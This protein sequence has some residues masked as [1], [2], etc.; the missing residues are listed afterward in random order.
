MGGIA[1]TALC[2]ASL[3]QTPAAPPP[4]GSYLYQPSYAE[5]YVL[6]LPA[7]PY[8]LQEGD[9][10]FAADRKLFWLATH[11][12]AGTWN[13]THSAV[14]FKRPDGTM[15]I[16]EAGPH[17]TRYCSVLDALPHLLSYEMEGRVWIRRRAVPLTKEQ[18][19]LLTEFALAQDGK[20]FAIKRLGQ[21][22]P[23]FMIIFPRARGPL[24]TR[25][26][27]DKPHGIDRESFYCSELCMEAL[28]YAGLVDYET[29]RPTATYPRD[30]FKDGSLNP[31]LNRHLKLAPCWDPPARWT[32]G[33]DI[34]KQCK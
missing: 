23:P 28:A 20:R 13:P 8:E 11:L 5:D 3:G 22:I 12:L 2:V 18:S 7:S 14:V 16:L 26:W 6:R 27:A 9:I 29:T 32:S 4:I 34:C 30:M 15:A 31:Y 17:D 19:A 10:M 1:L 33:M 24:R 25:W 21:Q